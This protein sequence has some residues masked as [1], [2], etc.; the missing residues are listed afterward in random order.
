[1]KIAPKHKRRSDG[2]GRAG[3]I[4]SIRGILRDADAPLT[5]P[6]I[7]A[8][9]MELRGAA[10]SDKALRALFEKRVA[11]ALRHHGGKSVTVASKAANWQTAW[12][13]AKDG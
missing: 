7:T 9:L 12:Q 2:S 3:V 11:N 10:T 5:K 8:R 1:M 4:R 6:D 13:V